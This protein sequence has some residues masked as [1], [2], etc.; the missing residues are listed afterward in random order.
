[1]AEQAG[2]SIGRY[3]LA[4]RLGAGGM[5][6][7]WLAD[8]TALGRQVALK[9]IGAMHGLSED[10]RG[11]RITRARLEAEHAARL[12]HHPH[13]AGVLDILEHD[14]LPWIVMEYVPGAID[15][16]A[17]VQRSGPLDDA[18][19]A[20][21]GGAVLSALSAGHQVGIIHRDV[22]PANILLAPDQAG[23]PYGRVSLTD[24]GISLHTD[25][26]RLTQGVI[27]TPGYL[28]PERIRGADP[29]PASDLFALGVTLYVASQGGTPFDSTEGPAAFV[30]PL[31][32]TPR[33]LDRAGAALASVI[34]GL[35]EKDPA[36]RLTAERCERALADI[37]AGR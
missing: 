23:R 9:A 36:L 1:M 30:A 3:R 25:S 14:G 34:M 11:A 33:P 20:Q 21:I 26:P 13:V 16:G 24:Y 29:S 28:A 4:R 32:E 37:A 10:E 27:G 17:V 5:G 2:S 7:V 18:E 19:V 6:S 35:L 22:K 15:L 12:S 8:D 31:L